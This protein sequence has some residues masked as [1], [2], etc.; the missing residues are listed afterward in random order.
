M[1]VANRKGAMHHIAMEI[2]D[3]LEE[4]EDEHRPTEISVPDALPSSTIRSGPPPCADSE[5]PPG[6]ILFDTP[7]ADC[8]VVFDAS[9]SDI[10]YCTKRGC[11][12]ELWE[13]CVE[14]WERATGKAAPIRDLQAL[15]LTVGKGN[16]NL[17]RELFNRWLSRREQAGG[18]LCEK[19]WSLPM[20]FT[21]ESDG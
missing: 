17:L 16:P 8:R 7:E 12:V 14:E 10:Q 5:L 9:D 1:A 11:S 15:Q 13:A 20:G 19:F 21:V 2:V 3:P 6:P 18:P 4:P